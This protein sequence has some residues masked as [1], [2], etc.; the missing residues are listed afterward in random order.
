MATDIVNF[1]SKVGRLALPQDSV[2]LHPPACDKRVI[3]ANQ[4]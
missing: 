3:I 2:T 4:E 1:K